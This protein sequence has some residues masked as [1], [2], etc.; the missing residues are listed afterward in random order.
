MTPHGCGGRIYHTKGGGG[1]RRWEAGLVAVWLGRAGTRR[2]EAHVPEVAAPDAR[3]AR[4][5]TLGKVVSGGMC[6]ED[7]DG[8][9]I[10]AGN[11]NREPAL[12]RERGA[13]GANWRCSVRN[14]PI[15]RVIEGIHRRA[16]TGRRS[17]YQ[18]GTG[19][20]AGVPLAGA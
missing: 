9:T 6:T 16:G 8:H 4:C 7:T 19:D 1:G 18:P 3:Q 12:R 5:G 14:G 20:A 13:Q 11:R 2:T 15:T 10:R 17:A